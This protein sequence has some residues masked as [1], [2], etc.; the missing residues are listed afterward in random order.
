[1]RVWCVQAATTCL[2]SATVAFS[3]QMKPANTACVCESGKS[4]AQCCAPY[5]AGLPAPNAEALMRSRYAAY[6]LRMPDYLIATWHP[7]TRPDSL[8][9]DEKPPI[10][11][12]GLQVKRS[13]QQDVEH[14]IVEFVARYKVNGKAE[15]LHEISTFLKVNDAWYYLNGEHE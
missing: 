11:W 6:V 10:K 1:M 3:L 9:L 15:R 8:N 2:N 14:A 12:L 5:H 7:D 4:Y 13:E